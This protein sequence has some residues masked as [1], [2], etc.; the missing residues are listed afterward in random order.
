MEARSNI[1]SHANHYPARGAVLAWVGLH[2]N[3]GEFAFVRA[4]IADHVI[5]PFELYGV[6][7][8]IQRLCQSQTHA[9]GQRGDFV[10]G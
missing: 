8:C 4:G 2:Q 3:A 5:R 9:D 10:Y 1:Q 7:V 6:T